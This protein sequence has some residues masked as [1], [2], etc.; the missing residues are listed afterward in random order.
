MLLR[1]H[2][3]ILFFLLTTEKSSVIDFL[4]HYKSSDTIQRT[5]NHGNILLHDV[6]VYF[7]RLDI[8]MA[9]QLLDDPDVDAIFKQVG[10]KTVSERMATDLFGNPGFF[11]G[12]FH[13]FLE[14]RFQH[15]VP[16]GF[17]GSGISAAFFRR[18]EILPS[19]RFCCVGVLKKFCHKKM[20]TLHVCQYTDYFGLRHDHRRPC[21]PFGTDRFEGFIDRHVKNLFVQKN[22]RVEG[23]TLSGCCHI[24]LNGQMGQK[25]LDLL[26]S[27]I[28][29][30]N[31]GTME[32]NISNNP[33]AV[34]LFGSIRVVVISEDLPNLV[35]QSEFRIWSE[36]FWIFHAI[37]FII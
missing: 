16:S 7:G 28:S 3:L 30:V 1:D 36:F 29:G 22:D 10:G 25:C 9:H 17:S 32:S 12:G 15:M 5:L 2:F 23:L 18:E 6:G 13:R 21:M 11:Y 31:F 8:G 37:G 24:L 14:A 20:K 35:H 4:I 34:S 26:F 27:H 19:Q 33:I